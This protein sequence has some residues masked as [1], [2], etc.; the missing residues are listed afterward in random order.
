[1]DISLNKPLFLEL[2]QYEKNGVRIC[3][4]E[5][6]ASPYQVVKAVSADPNSRSFM[7]DYISREDGTISELHFYPVPES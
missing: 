7:R 1:M 6:P 4:R 5:T 3:L 2:E